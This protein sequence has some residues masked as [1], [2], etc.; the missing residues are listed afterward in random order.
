MLDLEKQL[1]NA[2]ESEA[3][4]DA[5]DILGQLAEAYPDKPEFRYRLALKYLKTGDPARAEELIRG[6]ADDGLEEPL[7]YVNLGHAQKALGRTEEA[8]TAYRTVARGFDDV[9]ASIAWWS[10]AD[11]KNY[12]FNE[13][14]IVLLQGRAQIT[15]A[16]PGYRALMLF[17]L[18]AAFEQQERFEDAFMAMS[19][20]NLVLAEHRPF[21]AEQFFKLVQSLVSEVTAPADPVDYDGPTPIFIVGMPRSGTT[22]V[23]QVLAC[24]SDVEATDELPYLERFGLGLEEAGGYAK[25]LARFTPEQRQNFAARYLEN[26]EPYRREQRAYFIDKNP[27][28][29]LHVGLIKAIFPNAKVINVVRDTL[30]NAMSV[31]K[32]YFNRGNEFS[33]NMQAIVYYWQGYVSLMQHWDRLYPGDV[34]HLSY[35]SFT[36]D[37]DEKI[38]QILDHCGLGHEDACFRFWE[39]DRPVL[40]PSA[41]QVRNPVTDRSVGSGLKYQ[42]FIGPHIP[43]L[44]EI[45]RKAREVFHFG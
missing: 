7:M 28:N 22:M 2:E 27:T 12:H 9:S 38:R 25:A 17:A 21:Q 37:A 40:T 33:Y 24:H 13:Q 35:E 29:F 8:A 5:I 41:A 15:E 45:T 31:Y 16:A 14:E 42:E 4:F 43:A 11:L 26:V 1:K 44:A 32:Q 23:E 34:L 18:A 19:E 39:S 3:H 10:L 30:D 6:C 36:R 20:A